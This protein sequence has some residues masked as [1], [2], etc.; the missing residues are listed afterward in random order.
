MTPLRHV[1]L[2]AAITLLLP[3]ASGLPVS[4]WQ[5]SSASSQSL[6]TLLA[7][8]RSES[9]EGNKDTAQRL[10]TEAL[11]LSPSS[12][13]ANL[14]LADLML[15]GHRYPEAMERFE[16]ALAIDPRSAPARQG[17]RSAATALA[18]EARR[19]GNQEAAL[20]CLRHAS[21]TVPNDPL[22]L[23]HLGIQLYDM[24]QLVP[25]AE[26]LS[27]AVALAPQD[28]E[29]RYALARVE[30]DQ[31]SFPA[32]ERDFNAYLAA[33]P[34][35]AS[36]H[37]GLGHLLQMQQR[38][39]EA[40]AQFNESIRLQPLQTESYYQ[41]GQMALDD[42]RD[43]AAR[44]L[45]E[46]TLA[47]APN[48]GGAL[49][50]LGILAYRAKDYPAAVVSLEQATHVSPDYQPAHY[51]LGLTLARLNDKDASAQ[52]LKIAADLAIKQ[53]GKAAPIST[54]HIP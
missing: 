44:P 39:D 52:E 11:Q 48:H 41:L 20:L 19:A 53:Q 42:H 49:T 27:Q 30:L 24:H 35:D 43:A 40:S 23:H 34:S 7:E 6:V 25:A 2:I 36:A 21:E 28:P 16:A 5:S 38:T 14:A 17:E 9:A 15:D 26:A 32:A 8:A 51:Y 3:S 31:Q 45:F 33:R 22:L 47:R 46:H 50:G 37:Y 10:L 13:E 12:V 18:L 1:F 54:Q 29:N 4:S